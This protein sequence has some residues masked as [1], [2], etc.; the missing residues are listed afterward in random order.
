MYRLLPPD[1]MLQFNSNFLQS[2]SNTINNAATQPCF[3]HVADLTRDDMPPALFQSPPP[4]WEQKRV[5]K[6]QLS[7]SFSSLNAMKKG[8]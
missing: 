8:K 7:L 6:Q 3:V 5:Q 4:L 2:E 1:V